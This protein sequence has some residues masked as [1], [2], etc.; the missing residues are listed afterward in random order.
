MEEKR[1][2]DW[3]TL[4]KKDDWMS[5]WIGF[6][7]L[8]IFL[9]GATFKLP[10]WVWMTDGAFN[11]KIPGYL[12]KV[13]A[14]Q[15]D[16][17]AKG[18]SGVL[19]QLQA[20]K[21]AIDGKD[22]KLIGDAA[23]NLEKAAKSVK[24]KDIGKKSEKLAKDLKKDATSTLS[25]VLSGANLLQALYLL[26]GLWIL[27]SIGMAFMGMS[28]GKFALGFPIVYI[29]S[30]VSF[31]IAGNTTI[32]YYGLEVVFWALII[33]L[34]ISNTVG[35]PDWL[36]TAV[37]TEFFIKIGL[38]LLGAEV[39]FTTIAKVGAYGMVQSII[40]IFA[41]FYFCYWVAKKLGLD[42][43]FASILGTAVSICGVSAAI[44]A[45]GAVKGD[46]KKVSHTISLVLLCAIPM[47]I[48]QP[49]IA[50]AVGMSP[51]VAGA[52]IG[53]TID[54][55]GAVVAAGAIAGEAAM[56]VAVVVK[57]AQNVLIGFVAFLLAIWFTFKGLKTGEKPS[58]ME[59]WFRFPKFVV[60]FI[61]ASIVFS[62]FMPEATAKAVTGI[63]G[64]LRGW[65]FTLAFLCIGLDTQFKELVSMGGG[66]PAAAFL[67]AQLFNIFWTLL[68]A[69]LI[70][71]GVLFPVPKF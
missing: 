10:S 63:T 3:T 41:V 40:V 52:W 12:K 25:K 33:G 17:E 32:S 9:A 58:A 5:V 56:A 49:L 36:K 57:M 45:G 20:L 29:L 62:F 1:S 18:E 53:G 59:I 7:I 14:L 22:R 16:A 23:G 47:L 13:E 37:K 44:A 43:E 67:I 65:W 26:I 30:A 34:L 68:F 21:G 61:I 46:Q 2:I 19:S 42:D 71:G 31:F 28:V 8:I 54:T 55:T 11:E 66:K 39:L 27:G 60:G 35:V 64:G 70:F 69:W 24:D 51:A 48:F 15:K 50:K 6:L 4:W 38:V